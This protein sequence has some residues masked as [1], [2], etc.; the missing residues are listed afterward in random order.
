MSILQRAHDALRLRTSPGIFFAS[1]VV[2]LLFVVVTI[3]FTGAVDEIFSNASTWIMT[4]LGWFY[5]LGV[6]TFLLFLLGIAL[7]RYGRVR[8]GGDDERPEHSN[9]TWFSMLFAAGIGTILMFWAVAEPISHFANPPMQDVEPRS[10]EAAQ[11]AM[12]FALYHFGLH[13]WTIFALPGLCF[14]YFIYKRH[15]PPRVSSIFAPIL[16]GRIYGPIGHAI[17]VLAILGTVFGVATSVGLGTLQINAGLAQLFDLEE[18]GFIQ[19]GLIAI[20]TVMAGVSVAL[21]LDKGIKRLSNLNIGMA[22]GL[23]VF[24]LVTGPSL[25]LLKGMIESVGIYAEAL[26]RL[27]FWNDTFA[28]S[29]WQNTWT[30]FYWAWT[31]TWSPFVGIFI[32]RISRGRTIREFVGGVLGLPVL[33]SV[34]WFSIFGMGSFDI[35]LNGEGGLVDRVVGDGDIPGALFEFLGHFPFTGFVSF[36]AIV[37]VVIFFVT[38]VDSTAMVL[39]MMASGHEEKAPIHQRLFWAILMGLVAATMLVATGKDGLD[40]LQQLITVVGLPFFVMG[41]VMMYSLVRGIREDLGERPEPVTRQWP[42]VHTP[43]ALAAAEEL[44]APEVVVVTHAIP[45]TGSIKDDEEGDTEPESGDEDSET[46]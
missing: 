19:I 29:G 6:T 40:A 35:E 26:P 38:S 31:I 11:E 10:V 24:V 12:G 42:Q 34:I 36:I 7:T 14:G 1:A 45:D 18:S 32:A 23:L 33:F 21:G 44:P 43:E 27:A 28:N 9:I 46:R 2:A 20:V 37:L 30:V 3:A 25:F 8:L 17:D 13:T 15:L 4:N 5:V 16:G 22:V 41:F 39:D